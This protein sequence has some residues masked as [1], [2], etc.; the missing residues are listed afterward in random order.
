MRG[1]SCRAG[2][3]SSLSNLMFTCTGSEA[4]DLARACLASHAGIGRHRGPATPITA[5]PPR[6]GH[7]ALLLGPR[8][9]SGPRSGPS[10]H[11]IRGRTGEQAGQAFAA[12]ISLGR[13]GPEAARYRLGRFHRRQ[14]VLSP[15]GIIPGS[16]P[17]S[18]RPLID[19]VHA[20]GGIYIADEVPAG[21][22]PGTGE[23]MWGFQ[24]HGIVPD[25]VVMG[26][27]MGNGRP[28]AGVA[29]RAEDV[30]E[31]ARRSAISKMF[32]GNSISVAAASARPG[33]DRR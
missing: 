2:G 23:S 9:P 6:P 21:V 20:A 26:K 24:R 13:H 18:C 14:P 4:V 33:R 16:Q 8:P 3:R 7:L 10:R 27:P 22:R 15:T 1:S 29:A 17:D 5:S 31:S 28:I 11:R 25:L 32:G 30:A 12:R 19:A